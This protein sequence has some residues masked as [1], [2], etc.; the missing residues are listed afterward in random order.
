[1][2]KFD[3]VLL[4]NDHKKREKGLMFTKPLKRN[5]VAFFV[6]SSTGA[7][8]F[9]NKNVDYPLSLAFVDENHKIVDFKELKPQQ[10]RSVFPESMNV[11]YVIEAAKDV[12]KANNIKIG[13]T[14]HQK[15]DV[16]YIL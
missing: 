12:F 5:E 10:E 8:G 11:K 13:D 2:H 3:I 4:A 14:V 15:D 1:M 16:L 6:F 7:Y 9:W